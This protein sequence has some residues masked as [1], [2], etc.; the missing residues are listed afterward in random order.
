[1]LLKSL[2]GAY[3]AGAG[4][5]RRRRAG[6]CSSFRSFGAYPRCELFGKPCVPRGP[7]RPSEGRDRHWTQTRL[8][9]QTCPKRMRLDGNNTDLA[10][11]APLSKGFYCRALLNRAFDLGDGA[12]ARVGAVGHHAVAVR[13][14]L[15]DLDVSEARRLEQGLDRLALIPADLDGEDPFRAQDA[16]DLGRQVA[17]GLQPVRTAVQ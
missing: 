10:R 17:I 5:R 2:I 8:S 15:D 12:D 14:V 13:Q 7:P 1:M 16:G 4:R 11:G 6:P 3:R 9:E